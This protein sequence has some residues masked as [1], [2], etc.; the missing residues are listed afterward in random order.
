[1][2]I[3]QKVKGNVMAERVLVTGA[4]GFVGRAVVRELVA[5]GLTVSAL[6]RT[7]PID[8]GGAV[9]WHKGDLFDPTSLAAAV[10][11]CDAVIHLVGIIRQTQDKQQT[12]ERV[13][14]EGTARVVRT[15]E[16]AGVTR[17]V[18]MSALGARLDA[19][20]E[21]M[22]TKWEAEEHVRRS[23]LA[24][25]VFRPSVILGAGGEFTK[26]LL[27]WSFG[28]AFPYAFMPFF[29]K[30][31][32]GYR[33][34][35]KLQPIEVRDVARAF[36]DALDRPAAIGKTYD[37]VG[38][39]VVDWPTLYALA[40]G[41]FTGKQKLTVGIPAWYAK[42]LTKLVPAKWLPFNRDQVQMSQEDNTGDA[43]PFAEDF[44]WSPTGLRELLRRLR[45]E[46]QPATLADDNA[47]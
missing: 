33:P 31:F 4:G 26:M 13:H 12:F 30:G 17:Y 15:A 1:M 32:V 28:T 35:G 34:A 22:R 10:A 45:E 21:Y 2:R 9:T 23:T 42:T 5:R 6:V 36:V 41:A 16:L 29:G 40:S 43:A 7:L 38:S 24:T 44:G 14:V 3:E 25:T 11:G 47:T 27:A 46:E 18:Q 8:T 37:L 39:E 20:A 19:P